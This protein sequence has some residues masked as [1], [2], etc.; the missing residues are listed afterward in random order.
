M[1]DAPESMSIRVRSVMGLWE[2]KGTTASARDVCGLALVMVLGGAMIRGRF[3]SA[4]LM[5]VR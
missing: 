2:E 3:N 1:S 4:G 5:L